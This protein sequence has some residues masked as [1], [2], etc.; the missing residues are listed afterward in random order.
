MRIALMTIVALGGATLAG[1]S[2]PSKVPV[3][4]VSIIGSDFC[5]I[6]G[7]KMTWDVKDTKPTIRQVNRFNAKWDAKCGGKEA[8]PTS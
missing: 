4:P 7:S 8:K 6:A 3:Q 1:C 2:D 5:E